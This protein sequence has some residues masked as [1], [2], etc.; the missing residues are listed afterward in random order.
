MDA[1]FE[2]ATQGTVPNRDVSV[3]QVSN[4]F[5]LNG[6]VR[7]VDPATNQARVAVQSEG[8]AVDNATAASMASKFLT[9]GT[10]E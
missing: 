3:R 5:T 8:I 7:Y 1:N 6:V 9:T 2:A 10:F 4:G